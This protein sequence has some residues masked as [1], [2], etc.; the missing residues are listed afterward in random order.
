LS[1]VGN[2]DVPY[3]YAMTDTDIYLLVEKVIVPIN[4]NN[5][6]VSILT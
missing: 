1:P 5:I 4:K 3:T 2:S 6:S